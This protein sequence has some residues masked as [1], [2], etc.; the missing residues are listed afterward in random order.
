MANKYKP[1]EE[2]L[3]EKVDKS[4]ECWQWT[5][6]VTGPGYLD[7]KGYGTISYKG[8]AARVHRVSFEMTNGPIPDGI[9]VCHKCDNRLCVNPSHLFLGTGQDNLS[10][11]ANKG[12]HHQQVKTHCVNG[13]EFTPE[14]TY[15]TKAGGRACRECTI[16]HVKAYKKAKRIQNKLT[17]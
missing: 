16:S 3:W 1:I 14:N 11:M 12:R 2:R 13:H 6:A 4:G 9:M 7:G 5:G 17:H 8:R 10:D 15:K